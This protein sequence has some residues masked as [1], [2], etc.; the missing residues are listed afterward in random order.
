MMFFDIIGIVAT[1]GSLCFKWLPLLSYSCFHCASTPSSCWIVLLDML[2]K[3]AG[4]LYS[5][6]LMVMVTAAIC[7]GIE[8]EQIVRRC[9]V[10]VAMLPRATLTADRQS[11]SPCLFWFAGLL[12]TP[13]LP[14][15]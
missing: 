10:S 12:A 8:S 1:V 5:V 15:P 7:T 14:G 9:S 3:S 13:C 2:F 11:F 6:L 4:F